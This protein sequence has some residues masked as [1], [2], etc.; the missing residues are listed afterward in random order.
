VRSRVRPVD[1]PAVVAESILDTQSLLVWTHKAAII[2][3]L[4]A[5]I[6]RAGDDK[7]ALNAA[8]KAARVAECEASLLRLQREAESLICAFEDQGGQIR[9]TC[10]DPLVLLGIEPAR[11]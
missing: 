9:R 5:E 1:A 10:S 4:D 2:A 7:S 6:E 3:A 11:S 8:A